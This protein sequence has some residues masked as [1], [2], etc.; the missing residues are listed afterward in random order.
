[1]CAVC[2][3]GSIQMWDHRK[4]FVNVCLQVGVWAENI[5]GRT[6]ISTLVPQVETA[7]QFGSE[8]TGVQFAYD[9]RMLATRSND[10]TLKL[11]DVRWV[12]NLQ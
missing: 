7:H 6:N 8:I 9:N 5:L 3:D 2:N 11:W 1:M 12:N 10:E 4:N